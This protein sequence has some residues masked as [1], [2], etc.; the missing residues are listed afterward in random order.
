MPGRVKY[1]TCFSCGYPIGKGA[2]HCGCSVPDVTGAT[3]T[4]EDIRRRAEWLNLGT[5]IKDPSSAVQYKPFAR[6]KSP[7]QSPIVHHLNGDCW[8][9]RKDP[10]GSQV[11]L[12]SYRINGLPPKSEDEDFYEIAAAKLKVGAEV[13]RI[14]KE[15]KERELKGPSVL[16]WALKRLPLV[17]VEEMLLDRHKR[18]VLF[19]SEI[20]EDHAM[21]V[22]DR[23]FPE[24]MKPSWNEADLVKSNLI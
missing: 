7:T 22:I 1:M 5:S 24:I 17:V 18:N 19:W 2:T 11:R 15:R 3:L 8:D 23:T 16:T 14:T 21:A 6:S 12:S 9:S 4:G 13:D 10:L 20:V